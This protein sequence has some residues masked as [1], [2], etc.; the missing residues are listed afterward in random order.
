MY[1]FTMLT[2]L[3]LLTFA[4]F[5]TTSEVEN[6]E[7]KM[8]YKELK[9]RL[10]PIH[11]LIGKCSDPEDLKVLGNRVSIEISPSALRTENSLK[12][13]S[14]RTLTILLLWQCC[15]PHTIIQGGFF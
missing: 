6:S 13:R 9:L 8:L 3:S 11:H 15:Y 5:I 10:A 1:T 7:W 4:R 2:F 12:R 14:K